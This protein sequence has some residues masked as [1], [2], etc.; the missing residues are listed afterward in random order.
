MGALDAQTRA[1]AVCRAMRG[2]RFRLG[3]VVHR[4]RFILRSVVLLDAA[5]ALAAFRALMWLLLRTGYTAY[6]R[7]L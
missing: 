1:E 6:V 2:S 4:A 3:E 5:V 7:R